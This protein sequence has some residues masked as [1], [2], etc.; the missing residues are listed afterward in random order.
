MGLRDSPYRSLQW[1]TRL[2]LEVYQD[3][4][5][6]TNPFHWERVEMNLPGLTGYRANLPWVMKVRWDGELA[7]EVFVCVDD[8][9]PTGPTEYLAWQAGRAYW[10]GCTRR[11][12][13]DASRK[14]TSPSQTPGP[15]AGTVMHMDGGRI[16]GTVSQEKWEKTKSLIAEM[17]AMVE[18]DHLP[19]G[20]LLQ[21]W[22]FLMYVVRTYPWI[23]PYMKGLHLTINS[24]R[25]F[26]GADGFK[27]RGREL[28]NE[29]A[30]GVDDNLPC[31]RA[32]DD[33]EYPTEGGSNAAKPVAD[34]EDP[35]LEVRPVARFLAT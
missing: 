2:K 35:P 34:G 7:A 8:G 31:R 10:T 33:I 25:P 11:G 30:C 21:I 14:R 23:N 16:R 22:G 3:R 20:R 19:L 28:E 4:R 15:W 13:Q 17:A 1:Q 18:C 32:D 26:R 24:W 9:R 12:V 5:L 29:L 27:L 6:R